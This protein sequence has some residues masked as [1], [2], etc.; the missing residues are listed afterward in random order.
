MVSWSGDRYAG[1]VVVVVEGPGSGES[2]V[3]VGPVVDMDGTEA[4]VVVG[5]AMG[6]VVQDTMASATA[7]IATRS[8][9]LTTEIVTET[10][11]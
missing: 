5:S 7:A 8:F 11:S 10:G 9:G 2:V 1:N 4:V 3:E 6:S